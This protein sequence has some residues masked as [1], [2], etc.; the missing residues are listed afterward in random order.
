MGMMVGMANSEIEIETLK[1]GM[2]HEAVES[3]ASGRP[4]EEASSEDPEYQAEVILEESEERTI[5]G[6]EKSIE[7]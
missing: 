7:E 1:E 3:R 6:A 5:E 2:A 4:P